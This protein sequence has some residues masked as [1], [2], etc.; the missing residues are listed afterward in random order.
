M[1]KP[2]TRLRLAIAAGLTLASIL[3]TAPATAA[4]TT[5]A[6]TVIADAERHLGAPYRW[7]ATGPTYFDCSGL[8]Y[9]VF[10]E[11]G[12]FPVIGNGAYRDVV[13]IWGYFKGRGLA[14]PLDGQPGDLVVFGNGAHMGIY[15]G[16]GKVI[17][18]LTSGV[19]ITG[20]NAI[21]TPFTT[22][23]H[24]GLNGLAGISTV[25]LNLRSGP[26]TSNSVST[27]LATGETWTTLGFATDSGGRTWQQVRLLSGATGW[28]AGWYTRTTGYGGTGVSLN[29][30][31]G[32]GTGYGVTTVIAAGTRFYV[33]S[34]SADSQGRLWEQVR[35]SSGAV[36]WVAAWYTT[37]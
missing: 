14:S 27:V 18:A 17:S 36:G 12:Y 16:G 29:V 26:S 30:R 23:L 32:P 3:V 25:G 9:A 6:Q 2:V 28:V 15:L 37:P 11:T 34:A 33:L 31:T 4:A 8:V 7:G 22:F 21:S 35:L 5:P 24:T 20:I 10:R 1:G 13:Q 19:T